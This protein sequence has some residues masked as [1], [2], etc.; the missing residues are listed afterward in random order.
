MISPNK[1]IIKYIPDFLE[2]C[3]KN[4]N[5]SLKTIENYN[6]FLNPFVIWLKETNRNNLLPNELSIKYIQE[7]KNYLSNKI[8]PET[9]KPIKN[10]TQNYYLIVL[11]VLLSYF[12]EK[13][14]SSLLPDR[15]KLLKEE[16]EYQRIEKKFLNSEEFKKI[17][18]APD[19][20]RV[21]GLRDRAILVTLFST[22][23]KVSQLV[24]LNR[25]QIKNVEDDQN[26]EIKILYGRNNHLK[27]YLSK[28]AIKW[29]KE[30]LRTRKDK[31]KPLFINYRRKKG[32]SSRLTVRSVER[33]TKKYINKIGLSFII[34]PE[35]L[36][37]VFIQDLLNKQSEIK[38]NYP[39]QH[40]ELI[41]HSYN[42]RSNNPVEIKNKKLD[43][44]SSWHIVEKTISKEINWLK[45][46][47]AILP[48]EY[49]KNHS[50]IDC[51][52]CLL[53]KIAI[54]IVSKKVVVTEYKTKEI[55]LWDNLTKQQSLENI[56][57]RH[58]EEWHQ[59]IMNVISNY[60]KLQNYKVTAEPVMNY[61]RADLGV[62][63]KGER[64]LFIEVGTVSLFKIWY[65][66]STMKN[67]T[68]LIVPF[69]NYAIEFKI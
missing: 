68:L 45:N 18:Q 42:I 34:T 3:R 15:V 53:R 23:L 39:N 20:S 8:S 11:R 67:I 50:L 54:L 16:K 41:I 21:R 49:K 46:N 65:N 38:I 43:K 27:V 51:D 48:G 60:F 22:G 56:I 13:N 7:Y 14:I 40:N 32:T 26:L 52:D 1:S 61:G 2:Y 29:I 31:E 62:Y 19:V 58:G 5:L 57:N 63:K 24:S 33:I 17:L 66:L 35:T 37:N 64:N 59:K 6:R 4:K 12:I 25:N 47:I 28:Q 36:R 69:E 44:Y 9:K 55:D 30:Y 10:K